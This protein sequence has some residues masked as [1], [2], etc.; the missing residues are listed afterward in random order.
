MAEALSDL[1][2]RWTSGPG[3]SLVGASFTLLLGLWIVALVMTARRA[4]RE[5]RPMGLPVLSIALLP[6]A[7]AAIG[8]TR[9]EHF[10]VWA[11]AGLGLSSLLALLLDAV[12]RRLARRCDR[13]HLL[14]SAWA[15]CPICPSPIAAGPG[16][17]S[18]VVPSVRAGF[19]GRAATLVH[20]PASPPTSTTEWPTAEADD[21]LVRLVPAVSGLPEVVV[22]RPGASLGRN[23]AAE[24]CIDDPT[25]SWEHAQIVTRDG[26]P[27]LVDLGSSNGTYL[28]D[29]RVEQTLLLTGDELRLGGVSFRVLRP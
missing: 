12:A 24:V 14:S 11:L 6:F 9:P 10:L 20:R 8:L 3:P 13:S 15:F 19:V 17:S 27:A 28:N 22:R 4:H 23:P 2:E 29:E 5:W 21:V 7:V 26:A 1:W 18:A 25:V 16:A